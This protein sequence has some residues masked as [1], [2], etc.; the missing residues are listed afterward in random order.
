MVRRR[1]PNIST[2]RSAAKMLREV[3]GTPAPD[4]AAFLEESLRWRLDVYR[5][6]DQRVLVTGTSSPAGRVHASESTMRAFVAQI[7]ARQARP[8]GHPLGDAY[9]DGDGFIDAVPEL[10]RQL[11]ERLAMPAARLDGSVDGLEFLDRAARRVGGQACLDDPARLAAIVAYVGEVARNAVGGHWVIDRSGRQWEPT[12]VATGRTFRPFRI[13]KQ[14][15]EGGSTYAVVSYDLGWEP[16]D[17][18]PREGVFADRKP[19]VAPAV[20]ALAEASSAGYVIC[21]RYGDGR[22]YRIAI[23]TDLEIGGVPLAADSEAT[24]TRSGA[25]AVGVLSRQHAVLDISFPAGSTIYLRTGRLTGVETAILGAD[26]DIQGVPC[27]AGCHVYFRFHAKRPY[28]W[29]ATLAHAHAFGGVTYPAGTRFSLDRE[30][31]PED[32]RPPGR[33]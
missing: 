30:G 26:Q 15:L 18:R 5:L 32:E 16:G 31:T 33:G 29:L 2:V 8:P 22:P 17:A 10:I 6:A 4:L 12:I 13:F 23:I 20:G 24:V 1:N 28:L 7:A 3:G 21:R 19:A 25:L 9:P 27:Q 14:L 11:P